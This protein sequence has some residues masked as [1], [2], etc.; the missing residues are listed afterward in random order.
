MFTIIALIFSIHFY[1]NRYPKDFDAI[2][3][4]ILTEIQKNETLKPY[5]PVLTNICY[6]LIYVYSFCQIT[7]NNI[8][9]FCIPYIQLATK[10]V[11]KMI[12]SNSFINF[13]QTN[14]SIYQPLIK[15]SNLLILC[16]FMVLSITQNFDKI[17]PYAFT[18]DT[19]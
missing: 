6:N 2:I 15:P 4:Q 19:I 7:L 3:Q 18:E 14:L 11:A 1:K 17:K 10:T 13:L 9:H 5:L 12:S 8:I 16:P